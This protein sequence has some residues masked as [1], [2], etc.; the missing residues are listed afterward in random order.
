MILEYQKHLRYMRWTY[1]KK[2]LQFL[3]KDWKKLQTKERLETFL[4]NSQQCKTDL[5]RLA[6]LEQEKLKSETYEKECQVLDI[7]INKT[8]KKIQTL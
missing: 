4:I 7:L 1:L 8:R 6:S 5:L 2:A 3:S